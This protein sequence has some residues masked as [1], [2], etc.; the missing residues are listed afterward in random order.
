MISSV[1]LQNYGMNVF[2]GR[3]RGFAEKT[4]NVFLLAI[5]LLFAL[6]PLPCEV[7]VGHCLL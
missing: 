7:S 5:T 3:L 2:S 6:S 1:M 4:I